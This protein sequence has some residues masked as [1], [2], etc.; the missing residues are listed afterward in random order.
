MALGGAFGMI[1]LPLPAVGTGI[2]LS[3]VVPGL[4]VALA[5]K[6]PL[7]VAAA[8]VAA[9][10]IFHGCAHGAEMPEASSAV[11]YALGFVIATGLLHLAGSSSA[12][13]PAGKPAA[14]R[15]APPAAPS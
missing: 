14:S 4:C 10:A 11:S 3:A 5:L 12:P 8:I 2:A 9:F 6:P 13:L 7:P 15:S 1:G